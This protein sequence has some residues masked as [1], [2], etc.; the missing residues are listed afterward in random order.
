MTAHGNWGRAGTDTGKSGLSQ[1][2]WWGEEGHA[3]LGR[4]QVV[5]AYGMLPPVELPC[6]CH[7]AV[8]ILS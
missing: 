5:H 8:L 7:T 6:P 4:L 3:E 2:Q 1:V